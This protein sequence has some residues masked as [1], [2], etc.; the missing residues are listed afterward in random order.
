MSKTITLD[1][2][3]SAIEIRHDRIY[4][5]SNRRLAFTDPAE[6]L[7][8]GRPI[9]APDAARFDNRSLKALEEASFSDATPLLRERALWELVDRQ[10][11][12]AHDVVD[13]FMA[14]EQDRA[15]RAHA[16]W[17]LQK[18]ANAETVTRLSGY[19]SDDD[20]E[21]A[22]WSRLLVEELTGE[23]QNWS[24][25]RRAEVHEDRTFDQTLPLLIA[26]QTLITVPQ[27][28]RI[29]VTLSPLWFEQILGRVMACTNRATFDST[30]VIEKALDDL[31]PDGSTHYEV[32]LFKGIS[33]E[34]EPNKLF[35][36][37]YESVQ[38]RPFYPSGTVE[39]GKSIPVAVPLARVAGT[40]I[41][42]PI[43]PRACIGEGAR[44]D[45]MR[46][47]GWVTTVR[48]RY[49]GWAS[50]NLDTVLETNFVPPGA[51]QLSNPTHPVA[52]P[53]TN[54]VLFGTFRGKISDHTGTGA[55]DINT[56]PCHGTVDGEHDLHCDGAAVQD[57]FLQ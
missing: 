37:H 40:S 51:V 26:G 10:G 27:L 5:A 9:A 8:F 12:A 31:H 2:A 56:I 53:M 32:F 4:T 17:L 45:R 39:V 29:K 24:L 44:A 49:S 46:D 42:N 22:E 35:E 41:D 18:T 6:Y 34:L 3:T 14:E 15:C 43:D 16:L 54:A 48:G 36:H 13:R 23:V 20:P 52:G 47:Q 33:Y 55:L 21:V 57:P 7:D 38:T 11:A 30:L 19:F 50:V 1:Q 25:G 28:G